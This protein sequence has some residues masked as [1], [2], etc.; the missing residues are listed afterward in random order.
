[1]DITT[2]YQLEIKQYL[3]AKYESTS[4][5]LAEKNRQYVVNS[6]DIFI[7]GKLGP[8]FRPGFGYE[9][10]YNKSNNYNITVDGLPADIFVEGYYD[11]FEHQIKA[12]ADFRWSRRLRTDIDGSVAFRNYINYPAR[13]DTKT[14]TGD[15][16]KDTEISINGSMEYIIWPENKNGIA[17]F[18]IYAE[19]GYVNSIS[20]TTYEN[21]FDTNYEYATF[22]LG[23]HIDLP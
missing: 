21:S 16:R 11:F 7:D 23:L 19:A 9:F 13:D 14:F 12:R 10:S 17:D 2:A 5:I 8:V 22:L 3:N 1:M 18:G 4:G 20:N 6:G 15:K